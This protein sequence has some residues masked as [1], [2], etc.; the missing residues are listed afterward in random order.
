M[1]SQFWGKRA[2]L[3][4]YNITVIILIFLFCS[5]I[6]IPLSSP[7]GFPQTRQCKTNWGILHCVQRVLSERWAVLCKSSSTIRQQCCSV[8]F[9]HAGRFRCAG[10]GWVLVYSFTAYH[11]M[12]LWA[13]LFRFSDESTNVS[14]IWAYIRTQQTSTLCS[15][16]MSGIHFNFSL[17]LSNFMMCFCNFIS[18]K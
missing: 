1:N 2:E 11:S 12:L 3:W 8:Y 18:Y 5:R 17:C 9:T 16:Q 10:T 6:K 7:W 4:T 14:W 13:H 15:K